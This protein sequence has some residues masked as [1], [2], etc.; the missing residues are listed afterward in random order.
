MILVSACL[1]GFNCRYDGQDNKVEKILELVKKKKALPVCPEQLGGLPTPRYPAEIR[2]GSGNGVLGG[3]AKVYNKKG[4]DVSSFFIRGAEEALKLARQVQTSSAILKEGSPSCGSSL[5]YDGSFSYK[6]VAGEGL[7]AALLRKNGLKVYSE[8][9]CS[10]FLSE[11][12]I[13]GRQRIYIG[14]I[15]A[16]K[17]IS[18]TASLAREVGYL[19]AGRGVTIICGGRSGVMEEVCVGAEKKGACTIGILP[20]NTKSEANQA[21]DVV[22][23][24]GIGDARNAVIAQASDALIAID[25]GYGTL[26]EIALGLKLGRPVIGL[27]TWQAVNKDSCEAEI[28]YADTAVKAVNLAL[29][30]AQQDS[31]K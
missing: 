27:R 29:S 10:Q 13:P 4:A 30:F 23:A 14:V 28:V 31:E 20:G 21:V 16:S 1:C 26:S 17:C 8:E 3:K 9:N 22:L 19:L 25:G 2:N 18:E 12:L 5:V 6:K 24:T 7:T 15:G 11:L